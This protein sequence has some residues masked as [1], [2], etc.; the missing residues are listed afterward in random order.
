MWWFFTLLPLLCQNTN[1]LGLFLLSVLL[2]PCYT[3]GQL[4]CKSLMP[5]RLGPHCII[6]P[7]DLCPSR[8]PLT[9]LPI[10]VWTHSAIDSDD[11]MCI[12]VS[13]MMPRDCSFCMMPHGCHVPPHRHGLLSSLNKTMMLC[14]ILLQRKE[15]VG[16]LFE[17]TSPISRLQSVPPH[18]SRLIIFA[19]PDNYKWQ[20][21]VTIFK[22]QAYRS[23]IC[24]G[25]L[26]ADHRGK[27]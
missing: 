12:V 13:V 9:D 26:Y 24:S 22:V 2:A 15:K 7:S 14:L 21:T 25:M 18:S 3:S 19:N 8:S 4:R 5:S 20:S 11:G 16:Y 27:W 17:G 1:D 10:H 23:H 6:S